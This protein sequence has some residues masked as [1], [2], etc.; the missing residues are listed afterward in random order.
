MREDDNDPASTDALLLGHT[1]EE[2]DEDGTAVCFFSFVCP[3]D[4]HR[5]VFVLQA[6]AAAAAVLDCCALLCSKEL[7]LARTFALS[8]TMQEIC[9]IGNVL[10]KIWR[11]DG[12]FFMV[13]GAG[14]DS[15]RNNVL[16]LAVRTSCPF[17]RSNSM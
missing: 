16:L 10:K 5:V 8:S 13:E 1:N 7:G 2:E 4:S 9:R 3:F 12:W 17:S 15:L 14:G 11:G 6:A